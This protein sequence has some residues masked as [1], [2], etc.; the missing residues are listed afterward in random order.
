MV[1]SNSPVDHRDPAASIGGGRDSLVLE[2]DAA[3]LERIERRAKRAIGLERDD[4]L[5]EFF[6]ER[7]RHNDARRKLEFDAVVGEIELRDAALDLAAG[8]AVNRRAL[9]D[10]V[11]AIFES[12]AEVTRRPRRR[13]SRTR[14]SRRWRR[15]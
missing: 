13:A 15:W 4:A 11:A 9:E 5:F 6:V 2:V 1:S 8:G 12:N 10:D 14:T 7:R 3:V